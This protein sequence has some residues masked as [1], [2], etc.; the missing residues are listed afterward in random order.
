MVDPIELPR[1]DD[2]DADDRALDRADFPEGSVLGD[3]RDYGAWTR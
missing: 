2:V 3:L 1:R